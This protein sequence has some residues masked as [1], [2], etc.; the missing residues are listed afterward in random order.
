M[1]AHLIS[2]AAPVGVA[3]EVEL[4]HPCAGS[5]LLSEVE[6][7]ETAHALHLS[8]RELQIVRGVFNCQKENAIAEGLGIAPRTV[9]THLERLYRKL[10]V[11]TRVALVLRVME[12]A[13]LAKAS[14][15][16]EARECGRRPVIYGSSAATGVG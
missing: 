15:K 6:W 12:H 4:H 1:S 16:R 14:G 9:D 11:T 5:A 13:L 2:K 3:A 8:G 10:A 7:A